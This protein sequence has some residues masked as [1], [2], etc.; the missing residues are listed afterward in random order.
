MSQRAKALVSWSSGK[1]SAWALHK[2]R[3]EGQIDVVGLLTTFNE[4]VGRVAM[5]GV[6]RELVQEQ[7]ALLGLPLYPIELPSPC[8]NAEYKKRMSA[9]VRLKSQLGLSHMIFGDLFLAEIRAY[10]EKQM[11]ETG[12]QPVFP[13]WGLPTALLAKEMIDAGLKATLT[14][15]D[16]EQLP[17]SFSGAS[18]DADFLSRLPATVDSCGE[19]GE[20]HTLA[21]D[22]PMF[23]CAIPVMRGTRHGEPPVNPRFVFT[24]ILKAEPEAGT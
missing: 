12:L 22:G 21:H 18:F 11:A 13:L 1:D 16:T 7:A 15:V 3:T 24:D 5:H 8:S 20:F 14:C 23:R 2:V 4:D 19:N 6:R 9:L 17:A 10:R